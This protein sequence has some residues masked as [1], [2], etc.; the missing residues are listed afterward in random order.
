MGPPSYMRCVVDRNVVI[1]RIPVLFYI[2]G[3]Y[4]L[5]SWA[6]EWEKMVDG[7]EI[8][9]NFCWRICGP[10][11][12]AP[13]VQGIFRYRS[14]NIC[15]YACREMH[16]LGSE[17]GMPVLRSTGGTKGVWCVGIAHNCGLQT[18]V[19]ETCS[20]GWDFRS[21]VPSEWFPREF[22]TRIQRSFLISPT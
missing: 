5:V 15:L 3:A 14:S 18:E 8:G 22:S 17:S 12:W 2:H 4:E 13:K 10:L 9:T 21:I 6:G 20:G 11:M 16:I 7:R 1:L 19:C